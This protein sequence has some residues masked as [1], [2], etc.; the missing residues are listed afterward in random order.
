MTTETEDRKGSKN[1][2]GVQKADNSSE[3]EES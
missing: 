3:D 2:S 1:C